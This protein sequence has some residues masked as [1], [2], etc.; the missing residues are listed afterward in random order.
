MDV[1]SSIELDEA[2]AALSVRDLARSHHTSLLRFLRRRLNCTADPADVAQETYVRMLK[3]EGSREIRSPYALLLR[4][5]LHVAQDLSR[6]ERV[7]H[8]DQHWNV[9]DFELASHDAC[10]DRQLSASEE[11]ERVLIAIEELPPR[12]REVFLLHR[13]HHLSYAEIAE[14]C[15]ISVKMVE[16]H[17][18]SALTYCLARLEE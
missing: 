15:G 5:A 16:K 4:V 17:I 2:P 3:Y 12:R 6:S 1:Q 11:L 13:E 10:P 7:R 18:S 9:D 8:T 14:H